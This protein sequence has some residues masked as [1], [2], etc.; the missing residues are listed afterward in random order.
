MGGP[1]RRAVVW[2]HSGWMSELTEAWRELLDELA[3]RAPASWATILPPADD[4]EVLSRAL[5]V[6]L[7]GEVHEWFSL[8]GGSRRVL[9]A[10]RLLPFCFMMSVH[11]SIEHTVAGRE[12]SADEEPGQ[13]EATSGDPTVAGTSVGTWMHDYVWI[14]TDAMGGGLYLDLREGP[15]YG[16]VREWD[17]VDADEA[18]VIAESLTALVSSQ[19]VS[20]RSGTPVAASAWIMSTDGEGAIDWLP[21]ESVAL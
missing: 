10:G 18:D 2:W 7:S 5:D 3:V 20:L 13:T 21:S 9:E 15:L 12:L 4:P 14:G 17:K 1:S 6:S 8:H 11:E 19:L 16:C